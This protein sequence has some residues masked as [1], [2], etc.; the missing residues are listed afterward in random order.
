MQTF[1]F[2]LCLTFLSVGGLALGLLFGRAPIKGS[3]GG[4]S[5]IEGTQCGVCR[6]K[7][8]HEA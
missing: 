5:C 1:F 2:T 3:C 8:G 7:K 4:L 6:R